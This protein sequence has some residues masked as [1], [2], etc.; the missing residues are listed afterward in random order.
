[1]P[2]LPGTWREPHRDAE[3]PFPLAIEEWAAASVEV[4]EQVAEAYG[5][6]IT[7]KSLAERVFDSTGIHTRMLVQNLSA[8]LLNRVIHICLEKKLPALSALVVH[9]A[10]GMVG[11]GF[12]EVLRATGKDVPGTELEREWAAAA[13]RLECYRVYG[14]VPANAEP[15][16]TNTYQARV[17]PVKKEAPRPKPVCVVHGIQL[18]ATGV[19]DYCA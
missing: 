9:A 11:S 2:D 17:N 5:S 18:P 15:Q 3:I 8:R 12:D 16:L 1:V 13:E 6:C 14:K 7:Y 4:L 19:C 10:D